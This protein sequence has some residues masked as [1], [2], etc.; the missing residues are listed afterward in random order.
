MGGALTATD[1]LIYSCHSLIRET[2][3]L[4]MNFVHV[5]NEYTK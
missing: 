5:D 2:L 3:I 1:L 4:L